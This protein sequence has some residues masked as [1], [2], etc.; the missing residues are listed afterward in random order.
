MTRQY[1]E[2]AIVLD[3]RL[4]GEADRRVLLLAASGELVRGIAPAAARSRRRFG[5][6]LQPGARVRAR[7]TVKREGADAV[8]EEAAVVAAPPPGEPIE[9]LYAAAHV[10][11]LG[12]A[13]AREGAEDERLFRLVAACLDALAS[14]ASVEELM[15]YAEAWTLRLAGLL[16][17]LGRCDACGAALTGRTVRIA[18]E[19]GASCPRHAVPGAQSLGPAAARWLHESGRQP[20]GSSTSLSGVPARELA[21]A[22]PALVVAFTGRPLVAWPAL[23]RLRAGR[24]VE[25]APASDR[26][27]REDPP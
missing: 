1:E 25:V 19:S 20:P 13:F 17:D 5:G 11:E 26:P 12:A 16:G 27:S 21:R 23:L 24:P 14:G 8:L 15:R 2:E 4:L 6:A 22:L 18:P 3:S 7:W 9:R 10:L